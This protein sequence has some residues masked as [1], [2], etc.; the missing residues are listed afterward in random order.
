MIVKD[1]PYLRRSIQDF[2]VPFQQ[3]TGIR[4]ASVIIDTE[5]Y[6]SLIK[7]FK[8]RQ[9]DALDVIL[10]ATM[11]MNKTATNDILD[12]ASSSIRV[13]IEASRLLTPLTNSAKDCDGVSLLIDLA[14]MSRA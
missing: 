2:K 13:K 14:Y 6:R 3:P 7:M 10:E 9:Q 1:N 12:S 8:I 5:D 4:V 11:K